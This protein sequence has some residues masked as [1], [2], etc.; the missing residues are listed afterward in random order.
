MS[1]RF[2]RLLLGVALVGSP[3]MGMMP[4]QAAPANIHISGT[5]GDGVLMHSEPTVG[6]TRTGWLGERASPDYTCFTYGDTVGNVN[7]WFLVTNA[8]GATGYYPSYYDDSSYSSEAELT[9]RYGVPRC[10]NTSPSPPPPPPPPPPPA[11]VPVFFEPETRTGV[12]ASPAGYEIPYSAWKGCG[13]TAASIAVKTRLGNRT[14]STLAGWSIGR[15]GPV[16]LL[17]QSDTY[18]A[19][20]RLVVLVDPGQRSEMNAQNTCEKNAGATLGY[21]LSTHADNRLVIIA[22]SATA[23]DGGRGLRDF[24]LNGIRDKGMSSRT[25]VCNAPGVSHDDTVRRWI[26]DT[27]TGYITNPRSTCPYGVSTSRP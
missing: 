26:N 21:W 5:G 25:A 24:Y 11:K 6:S 7:V 23:K 13:T 12:S 19:S 1:R 15:L 8:G 18:R 20:T 16:Y 3:L 2:T 27:R 17:S 22:G 9:S 14:T 4:A 10:G